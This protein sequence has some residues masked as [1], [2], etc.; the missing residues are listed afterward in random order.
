MKTYGI[1]LL[2]GCTALL[3]QAGRVTISNVT[4]A[5]RPNTLVVDISYDLLNPSGG[6]HTVTLAVSTNAGAAYL[7]QCTNVSG[8]IGAGVSTGAS[9]QIVWYASGDFPSMRGCA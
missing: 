6:V 7:T 8:A 4:A 2:A 5:Q 9:K 1:I 3:A